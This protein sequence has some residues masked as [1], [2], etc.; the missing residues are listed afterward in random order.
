[1]GDQAR[2]Y[3]DWVA[4]DETVRKMMARKGQIHWTA[5]ATVVS[6][7]PEKVIGEAQEG[8]LMSVIRPLLVSA[9]E[10]LEI[11]SPY[12]IPGEAGTGQLVALASEGT[13]VSVLTNSLAATDVI[14]VHGAYARY[15][16]ALVRGG[17]RLF[18]LK[19]YDEDSDVSL[20]GSSSASLHTK[21]F[22]VDD[23]LGFVGSMN[24]DPRSISLNSEMGV[25]FEQA[26]LVRQVREVFADETSP[27]KSYRLR[28]DEGEIV[29]QDGAGEAARTHQTEPGA[30]VWRRLTA[31]VIGILPIE[32]QL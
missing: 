27:Q 3:L 9:T 15:R 2:L 17:V 20:F 25:V 7:P 13:R 31:T 1:V 19:P 23:R 22:T 28:L 4:E 11:I 18:E 6:D 32:S 10:D 21:A 5:N 16:E 24:F 14:A 30:S 29:W 8:W 26:G 12:F